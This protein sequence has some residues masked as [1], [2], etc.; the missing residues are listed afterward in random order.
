MTPTSS[1][2]LTL[3]VVGGVAGGMS[4]AARARRLSEDAN[5]IVFERGPYPSF[6]NCGL[7]YHIGGEIADRNKL[8]VQSAEK[9]RANLALDMRTG[10]EVLSINREARTVRVRQLSTQ[11]EFEQHYDYLVLSPGASPIKPPLPG[12]DLP[13]VFTLRNIPDLDRI[14][15]WLN[16]HQGKRAVVVG[17]GYI[18]LEVAEQLAHRGLQVTTAEAAPQ[19]MA[20]LDVEMAEILHAEM[21]ANQ[22][23]LRLGDPLQGIEPSPGCAVG[24]VILK[25]GARL[26]ADL[27]IL[28][29]GVRPETTLAKAA[30]LQ[31]GPRQGIQVDET[32]RTNDPHIF[33]IGDAAEVIDRNTGEPALIP[34]AGPANRQGRIVADQ[35]FGRGSTYKSTQGTA[36]L[37]LFRLTAAVT[38][39]NARTLTRT[40]RAFRT[41]HLHPASHASYYPGA[42]PIALKL[43]WEPVTGKVLG[44]QAVGEDGVDKRIDVLAVA[45]AAGMTIDDLAELELSYAPPFGSAKDPVN[46]A[47]M[48]A[49]NIE[50]GL[51]EQVAPDELES[52]LALGALLLDVR[53]P[54]ETAQGT[55]PG[56]VTIPLGQLRE[57]LAELPLDRPIVAYCASGLRSY[58]ASRIL[59]QKGYEVANLSGAYKTWSVLNPAG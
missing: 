30:G 57:R 20:P 52:R 50:N 34:L 54:G 42:K 25:S 26:P 23:D 58:Q 51:V 31:L 38:G 17:G 49:Q 8:I 19:V 21:R 18:G 1:P 14:L 36:V 32:L 56:A 12:L 53:E 40:G 24:E 2:S 4:F 28:G 47:G 13:G 10:H 37:R 5:I 48:A 39:A 59:R 7:P 44:A 6:A 9:L 55:I 22:V 11:E 35:I 29:L 43:I 45:I 27:V 3:V 16:E 33:A 15:A 46:L 41:V